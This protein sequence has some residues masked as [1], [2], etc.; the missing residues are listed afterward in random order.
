MN[1]STKKRRCWAS[2]NL[3]ETDGKKVIILLIKKK[4]TV[5][6]PGGKLSLNRDKLPKGYPHTRGWNRKKNTN[7][8]VIEQLPPAAKTQS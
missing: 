3:S 7:R 8:K 6:E 5:V 1:L 4:K 2:S